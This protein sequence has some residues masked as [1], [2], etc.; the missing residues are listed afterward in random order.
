MSGI[1]DPACDLLCVWSLLD[2]AAR[3][4]LRQELAVDEATWLRGRGWALSVGVIALP[5]YRAS[6][7][8]L[9]SVAGHL[10]IEVLG[11]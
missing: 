3:D 7:P 10:I 4:R 6:H 11:A 1:G 9:A 2:A 8:A 5:Y